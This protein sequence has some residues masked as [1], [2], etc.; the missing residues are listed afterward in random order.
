MRTGTRQVEPRS[1]QQSCPT[2]G[3]ISSSKHTATTE[4]EP[5]TSCHDSDVLIF[6]RLN[7]NLVIRIANSSQL[8]L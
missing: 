5:V 2:M 4:T 1:E 3:H 6:R 8:M 7:R